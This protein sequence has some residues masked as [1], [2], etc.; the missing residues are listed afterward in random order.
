MKVGH[1]K[2][3]GGVMKVNFS[4][5]G[6]VSVLLTMN[7]SCKQTEDFYSNV[8]RS[9]IYTQ[10]YS[11][12]KVDFL[13]VM[14]NSGSMAPRRQFVR[15]NLQ[16]F[17]N[18]LGNRKAADYQMAFVTTNIH[19]DHG[20]LV[21]SPT[22]LEVVKST[23]SLDPVADA[24]SIINN[25]TDSF[26]SFWE[27]G[28][29]GAYQALTKHKDKF[30]RPG[31]PLIIVFLADEDDYSCMS[32]CTGVEPEHNVNWQPYPV[33]RYVEYFRNVKKAENTD[34]HIFP[35]VITD[36]NTCAYSSVGI[37]YMKVA[38]QIGGLSQSASVCDGSINSSYK[39]VAKVIADRAAR[40]KLNFKSKGNGLNVY[41]NNELVPYHPDNYIFDEETNEVVF[42][43]AVPSQGSLIYFR[44]DEVAI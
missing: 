14:D 17:V 42:T 39:G 8:M 37:R 10:Q 16:E 18:L 32:N 38:E 12:Q 6:V 23:E 1:S 2:G 15:D 22:G 5:W 4:F 26:S 25:I 33:S 40:F 43:G 24:A 19:R 36:T 20:D 30:S 11:N 35:I 3:T 31:V 7:I 29:E 9:D 28:L 34:V 21:Q 41:V 27:Q 44:Y 13:W